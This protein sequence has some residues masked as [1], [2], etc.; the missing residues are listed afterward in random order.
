MVGAIG[1][2]AVNAQPLVRV[3]LRKGLPG[4]L[5][6][7][8]GMTGVQLFFEY[9][10]AR[11]EVV[12]SLNALAH[13]FTPSISAALWNYQEDLLQ[14][15]AQGI[16][17]HELVEAVAI[18]DS[19]GRVNITWHYASEAHHAPGLHIERLLYQRFENEQQQL[20]GTLVIV[21]KA[22][23]LSRCLQAVMFSVC[24]SMLT[25]LLFF[26][27]LLVIL[28]K[29]L[30][31]KP[32]ACFSQQI[33]EWM[34]GKELPPN[35]CGAQIAEIAALHHV[36]QQLMYR[37]NQGH[38]LLNAATAE[39]EQRVAER[40]KVLDERNQELL[41]THRVTM[42]LVRSIP[43]LVC[44]LDGT[45]HIIVANH[46]TEQLIEHPGMTL[47]GCHWSVL[48]TPRAI[49]DSLRRLFDQ[50]Y[51]C[52]NASTEACFTSRSGKC[53]AYQF[54]ALRIGD[55][56]DLRIVVIGMDVTKQHDQTLRLQHQ[57][58]YDRLTGLPNRAL[59][60]EHLEQALITNAQ[61]NT[62][63]AVAFLDLDHFK[64]INDNAG[65]EAGDA[66]L[67][68]IAERLRG[69]VREMD[70]VARYGGDEF[71]ALFCDSNTQGLLRIAEALLASATHPIRWNGEE[72]KVSLSIGFALFPRDGDTVV[73]LLTAADAAMYRAKQAGR[74]RADFGNAH[75]DII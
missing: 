75:Q 64:P 53:Y 38:A 18:T 2:C 12:R 37:V 41:R 47:V 27:A 71:V 55:D 32:L 33:N 26:G 23:W 65:H 7:A 24:V 56:A 6:F 62:A 9:R 35:I 29:T 3:L 17:Q 22:A 68:V 14:A 43:G 60:L 15:L 30:V 73:E 72:F 48:A 39:L 16:G 4:Y 40:T 31:V 59:F 19:K 49:D 57:A 34:T 58:F 1:W 51:L 74:N 36:F 50:V 44:I 70:M 28:T 13:T 66:V 46:A 8:V 67:S 20:L 42:A 69:C 21:S 61:R 45:G 52:G 5:M 25:Q 63:F 11:S 54:E 10:D